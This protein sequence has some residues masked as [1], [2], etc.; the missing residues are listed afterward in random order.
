MFF[1]KKTKKKT[2]SNYANDFANLKSPL[3]KYLISLMPYL[4]AASLLTP[5][6]RAKPDH[7]LGSNHAFLITLGCTIPAPSNSIHPEPLHKL[8]HFPPQIGHCA[9][10]SKPGS[11]KGK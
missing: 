4:T 8:H 9:S 5:T 6:H 2:K 7:S 10:I 3:V 1:I 11:T